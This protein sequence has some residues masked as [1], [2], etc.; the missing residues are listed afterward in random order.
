MLLAQI[1]DLTFYFGRAPGQAAQVRTSVV[2]TA[3]SVPSISCLRVLMRWCVPD[4]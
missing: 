1:S 4:T 3:R 2:R